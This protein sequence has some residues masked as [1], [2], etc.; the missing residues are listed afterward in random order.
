MGFHKYPPN[1]EEV[2]WV[3]LTKQ[4]HRAAFSSL[5]EKYQR[6]VY[7]L[8]YRMLEDAADAEDATQEVFLRAY[9]KLDSYDERRKFSTWLFAITSHYCLDRLRMRRIPPISWDDLAGW[10]RFSAG[11]TSQPET[12]LIRSETTQEARR[13]LNT[14]PPDYR[15]AVIL[16][17][18]QAMSYQEIAETLNT[19]VSAIKSKLFR[20]RKMMAETTRAEAVTHQQRTVPTSGRLALAAN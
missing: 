15:T 19:T 9:A 5:V 7:N 12:A 16:K 3:A 17:Y 6:P 8:C 11:E 2:I 4:G 1:P 10:H 18:W 20:A 13:L 14:L